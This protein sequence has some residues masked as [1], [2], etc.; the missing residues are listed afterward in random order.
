MVFLAFFLAFTVESTY[1]DR[2]QLQTRKWYDAIVPLGSTADIADARVDFSYNAAGRQKQIRRYSDLSAATKVGSTDYTYDLSGRTNTLIHK[3]AVDALL[4]SYDYNYDFS[5]LLIGEIRD[6]Q[7]DA[8]DDN[9]TYGYD[10]TG[11][12][13]DALFAS[14]DDEH[15]V[16]DLNGNR[17]S[18]S[19]GANTRTYTTGPANQLSSDGA[20]TYTYDGEGNQ[21]TKTRISDGQI[22]ENFWDHHNRLVRVEERSAGGIVLKTVEFSYDSMG[23]RLKETVNGTITLRVVHDGDHTWGDFN[24]IGDADTVYL[25][26]NKI[27]QVVAAYRADARLVWYETDKQGT[28]RQ[29]VK[30]N[31]QVLSNLQYDAFGGL[32]SNLS[33]IDW[34][35]F[36]FTGRE[37]T[38]S[39]GE[40]YF[41]TRFYSPKFGTFLSEDLNGFTA[42]DTNLRRFVGNS[43]LNASDPSGG[44]AIFEFIV[45]SITPLN[46][47]S[48][49]GA[50]LGFFHGLALSSVGFISG[51]LD[52][53]DCRRAYEYADNLITLVKEN[54]T[55]GRGLALGSRGAPQ[56]F[57]SAYVNG[58]GLDPNRNLSRSGVDIYR[59]FL[60]LTPIP[61]SL[62]RGGGLVDGAELGLYW[63][64]INCQFDEGVY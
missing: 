7:D 63:A 26:T 29:L 37:W 54:L 64:S 33:E 4:S 46:S 34:N 53:G 30:G 31:G 27:D 40:Y 15:Y 2:N 42:A 38:Q 43:V 57:L 13:V 9:I 28:I 3:N 32:K 17:K 19:V 18:S 51:F 44:I 45:T 41:R 8:F 10:L 60:G 56:D 55:R 11:Q 47:A 22:T 59:L 5:G 24:A 49:P 36:A 52:S 58:L 39:I 35:R 6:Q 50:S 61:S 1:S 14:Q 48:G 21:K 62:T 23:R 25:Y 12:L 20:F 16:Y